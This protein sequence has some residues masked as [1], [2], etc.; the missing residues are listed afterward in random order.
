M[1]L[2][3]FR[4]YTLLLIVAFMNLLPGKELL[5]YVPESKRLI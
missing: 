3:N 4:I 1:L 5:L 2:I